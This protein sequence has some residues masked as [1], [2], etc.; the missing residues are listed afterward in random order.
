MYVAALREFVLS[1]ASPLRGAGATEK[2]LADIEATANGLAPFAEMKFADFS[3]L[4]AQSKIYRDTGELPVKVA[5]AR[6]PRKSSAK[7]KAPVIGVADA[8][9]LVQ[10]L[11]HEA[12]D[13]HVPLESLVEALKPLDA[14]KP[15]E[16]R[17]VVAGIGQPVNKSTSGKKCVE[18]IRKLVENRKIMH[19]QGMAID[20]HD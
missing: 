20:R 14:V 17:A 15:T 5:P 7:P 18:T 19:Q 11:L 6:A 3:E 1:L 16:L 10:R 9:A 4:L 12:S 13:E 8:I 2:V